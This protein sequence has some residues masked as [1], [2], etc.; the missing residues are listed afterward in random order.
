MPTYSNNLETHQWC[1]TIHQNGTDFLLPILGM[2]E[3]NVLLAPPSPLPQ[4]GQ[5]GGC[6]PANESLVENHGG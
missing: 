6:Y 1:L 3:V 2:T 4:C 5:V